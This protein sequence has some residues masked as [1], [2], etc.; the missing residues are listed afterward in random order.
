MIDTGEKSAEEFPVRGDTADRDAGEALAMIGTLASD[1]PL[2]GALA[3][4]VVISE[5][6][7]QRGLDRFRAGIGEEHMVQVAWRQRR[8]RPARANAFGCPN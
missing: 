4:K 5:G 6:D 3:T 8:Y 7:F 1:Q 2:P